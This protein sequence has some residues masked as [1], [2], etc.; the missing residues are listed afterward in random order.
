MWFPVVYWHDVWSNS[1]H[2]VRVTIG[3]S[4]GRLILSTEPF[5]FKG[6]PF[7]G[8]WRGQPLYG[9]RGNSGKG[10]WREKVW[11]STLKFFR[12]PWR[13]SRAETHAKMQFTTSHT[14][15]THE[16]RRYLLHYDMS[17]NHG[18][19]V[20][21]RRPIRDNSCERISYNAAAG[22]YTSRCIYKTIDKQLNEARCIPN[23]NAGN[24]RQGEHDQNTNKYTLCL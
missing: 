19:H 13:C 20:T 6:T 18:D 4:T 11:P 17:A 2:K 3:L 21:V 22:R 16:T 7:R 24:G 9:Q 8:M 23:D 10:R 12:G 14:T 1:F 15:F 5:H